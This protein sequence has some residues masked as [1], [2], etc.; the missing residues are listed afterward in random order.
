MATEVPGDITEAV[1][2]AIDAAISSM[3]ETVD[4]VVDEEVP[5][6]NPQATE[7]PLGTTP[8]GTSLSVVDGVELI[9]TMPVEEAEAIFGGDA[10]SESPDD[11][12]LRE[13][14]AERDAEEQAAARTDTEF[15]DDFELML[16][17]ERLGEYVMASLRRHARWVAF[18][19]KHS[20]IVKSYP[21]QEGQHDADPDGDSQEVP[22]VPELES[23]GEE[24]SIVV[25]E[26]ASLV[27][28]AAGRRKVIQQG[29]Q[30][31][32]IVTLE[33]VDGEQEFYGE[34]GMA[35]EEWRE[36]QM[37]YMRM[38]S[39]R[40]FNSE[41][42]KTL[43]CRDKILAVEIYLVEE[44][45]L[46]IQRPQAPEPPKIWDE[47]KR[48]EE[49]AV[50]LNVRTGLIERY[51]KAREDE[52]REAAVDMLKGIPLAVVK[53]PVWVVRKATSRVGNG[54]KSSRDEQ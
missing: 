13:M 44:H 17:E 27:G 41:S 5:G 38:Q 47:F 53:A 43:L 1:E 22:D 12:M 25:A 14:H 23:G 20:A 52:Q 50:R 8:E 51:K 19:Q 2:G 21:D 4:E 34:N 31:P 10:E 46:T 9:I 49:I 15:D 7:V 24:K 39:R 11:R 18:Q 30:D 48:N 35:A 32:T 26:D 16:N 29:R 33:R 3:D 42:S 54:V 6:E 36:L 40:D 45:S 28:S 37:D